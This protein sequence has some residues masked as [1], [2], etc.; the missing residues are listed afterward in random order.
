MKDKNIKSDNWLLENREW[1]LID[2]IMIPTITLIAIATVALF[3]WGVT[4]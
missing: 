3:I 4:Q 1:G 2:Y